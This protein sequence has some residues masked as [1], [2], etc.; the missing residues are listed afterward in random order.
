MRLPEP[1]FIETAPYGV[2]FHM[3]HE[4]SVTLPELDHIGFAYGWYGISTR[5]HLATIDLI[6][7]V[8]DGDVSDHGAAFLGEDVQILT[9]GSE[10]DFEILQNHI[11]FGLVVEGLFLGSFNRVQ[12]LVVHASKTECLSSFDEILAALCKKHRLHE[13]P[14]LIE[15]EEF[16]TLGVL[17]HLKYPLRLVEAHVGNRTSRNFEERILHGKTC[18][19]HGLGH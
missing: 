16:P 12:A 19:D 4:I 8:E 11:R 7:V 15:I 6:S 18:V 9:Q 13:L 14:R 10:C 1:I 17:T 5:P 2:F 3:K